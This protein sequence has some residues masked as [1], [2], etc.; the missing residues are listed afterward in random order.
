[1]S[2][3]KVGDKVRIVA[4]LFEGK[5]A[6]KGDVGI[7]EEVA[8]TGYDIG[9]YIRAVYPGGETQPRL[10]HAGGLEWVPP[11][12]ETTLKCKHKRMVRLL[13][14]GGYGDRL[15][16]VGGLYEPV[17]D[18]L[19]PHL[20]GVHVRPFP[21]DDYDNTHQTN[22]LYF[23]RSEF[24]W[25]DIYEVDEEAETVKQ[26]EVT[27]T[28]PRDTAAAFIAHYQNDGRVRRNPGE[29]LTEHQAVRALLRKVFDEALE[30]AEVRMLT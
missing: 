23:L 3:F 29:P 18:T 28:V 4:D 14:H 13:T 19:S 11:H 8:V 6:R 10:F 27:V 1:M 20:R 17:E 21:H 5:G 12:T 2:K 24:E 26:D 9:Y 30:S 15:F 25:E 7:I 16:R 22:G